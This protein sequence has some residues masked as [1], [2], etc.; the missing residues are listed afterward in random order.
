MLFP[1][2]TLVPPHLEFIQRF[3]KERIVLLLQNKNLN[4]SEVSDEMGFSSRSF[5]T[6]YVKKVL[7]CT[8]SDYRN[9][10][11]VSKMYSLLTWIIRKQRHR[12]YKAKPH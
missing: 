5:F 1:S 9:R 7:G 6:R 8:P 2:K 3:T 12:E 4:I 10:L 11:G